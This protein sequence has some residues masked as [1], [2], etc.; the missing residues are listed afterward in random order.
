MIDSIVNIWINDIAA[1]GIILVLQGAFS[2]GVFFF[3]LEIHWTSESCYTLH[4]K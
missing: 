3:F 2:Y 1:V 4:V